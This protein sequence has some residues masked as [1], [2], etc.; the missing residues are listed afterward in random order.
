MF[1]SRHQYLSESVPP[2]ASGTMPVSR[3]DENITIDGDVLGTGAVVIDG[4]VRGTIHA[5]R[6]VVGAQGRI[7]GPIS[8]NEVVID[9]RVVGDVMGDTVTIGSSARVVGNVTHTAIVVAPG[10]EI[11]GRRPWRPAG[12]VANG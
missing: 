7:A 12:H 3:L 11:E 1:R 2:E 5:A 8:A 6:V 9:G 4:V 10:A